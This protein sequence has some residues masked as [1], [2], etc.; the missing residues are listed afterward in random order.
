M[1]IVLLKYF[2]TVANTQHMTRAAQELNITQPSLSAAIRRLESELGVP[3]FDRVGRN[4]QLNEYGRIFYQGANVAVQSLS[5]SMDEIAS[6]KSNQPKFVQMACSRSPANS[7]LIDYLLSRG[8]QLKVNTVPANWDRKLID[9]DLDLVITTGHADSDEIESYP[10]IYRELAIVCAAGHPL[11]KKEEVLPETLNGY[12]FCSTD[13]PHSLINVS[14]DKLSA[15][16]ISPRITFL[17]QNSADMLRAIR[18]GRFLGLMVKK[19]LPEDKE[20]VILPVKGFDVA[21]PIY[22]HWRGS[23]TKRSSLSSLR[24]TI[25]D[26]YR[27]LSEQE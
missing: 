15:L 22:L 7:Q 18:T 27:Q 14:R 9:R 20:L 5:A 4:I 16:G 11:A 3:L 19:N 10:L 26:F 13:A 6:Q 12:P 21:I 25:I 1:D 8:T 24:Q 23:R 2:L 17:G